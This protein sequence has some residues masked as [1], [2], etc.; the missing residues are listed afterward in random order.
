MIEIIV[1]AVLAGGTAGWLVSWRIRR[2]RAAELARFMA[3]FDPTMRKVVQAAHALVHRESVPAGGER[4]L[5]PAHL[6]S[7]LLHAEPFAV[8]I[9]TLGGSPAAIQKQVEQE[10]RNP[11]L[12][13]PAKEPLAASIGWAHYQN[14]PATI[15]DLWTRIARTDAARLVEVPPVDVHALSFLLVHGRCEPPL[16]AAG[17]QLAVVFHNDDYTTVDVVID[18]L[19]EVFGLTPD[20]AVAFT[21]IVH[22]NGKA[23][24]ARYPAAE[25]VARAEQARLLARRDN[26]VLWIDVEPA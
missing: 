20:R 25:A 24:V 2:R 15:A 23:V 6:I 17:E 8:A 22:T 10:V 7:A 18:L 16:A 1:P 4:T 9:E 3:Y 5:R 14:R 11:T 21:K 19:R 12:A 26:H 13:P